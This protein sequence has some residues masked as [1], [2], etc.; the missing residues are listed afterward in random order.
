MRFVMRLRTG[1]GVLAAVAVPWHGELFAAHGLAM[2]NALPR[3]RQRVAVLTNL[4]RSGSGEASNA[5]ADLPPTPRPDD[6]VGCLICAGLAGAV[7][8]ALPPPPTLPT[9]AA[10]LGVVH[11]EVGQV[12]CVK[13]AHP[14]ARGPPL[15]A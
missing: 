11:A 2:A 15:A 10:A 4:R 9:P 1:I 13:V 8:F 3:H 5:T 6:W 14:P 12:C 7:L